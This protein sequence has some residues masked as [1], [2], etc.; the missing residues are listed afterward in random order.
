MEQEGTALDTGGILLHM[1]RDLDSCQ[2][3]WVSSSA[4]SQPGQEPLTGVIWTLIEHLQGEVTTSSE[5]IGGQCKLL[6]SSSPCR[7]GLAE[8]NPDLGVVGGNESGR[9]VPP[10]RF[11]QQ[12]AERPNFLLGNKTSS[13]C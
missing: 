8:V 7:C 6:E 10:M 12:Q 11:L 1:K 4:T 5:C 13:F 2:K 9:R 3:L